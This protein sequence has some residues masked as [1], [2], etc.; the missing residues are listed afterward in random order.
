MQLVTFD[1]IPEITIQQSVFSHHAMQLEEVKN[2]KTR[3][4]PTAATELESHFSSI[5]PIPDAQLFKA[6][7]SDFMAF[8]IVLKHF[9]FLLYFY[10]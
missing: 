6:F 4:S 2:V 9:K 10:V 5:I 1:I 3:S 7:R 8:H